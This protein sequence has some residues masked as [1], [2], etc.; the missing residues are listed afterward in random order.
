MSRLERLIEFIRDRI[1]TVKFYPQE[2]ENPTKDFENLCNTYIDDLQ[3]ILEEVEYI[4]Y[5]LRV[6]KK[7][8]K[9]LV[10]G[11]VI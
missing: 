9:D 10:D 8:I 3:Q 7:A 1:D 4:A 6:S 5:V 2:V 11:S